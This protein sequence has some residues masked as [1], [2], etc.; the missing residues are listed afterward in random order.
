LTRGNREVTIDAMLNRDFAL[1]RLS[2]QNKMKKNFL[3]NLSASIVHL[4]KKSCGSNR[5]IFSNEKSGL[6][7]IHKMRSDLK[8]IF[9]VLKIFLFMLLVLS[10]VSSEV[11]AQDVEASEEKDVIQLAREQ[12]LA[13]EENLKE[14]IVLEN[15]IFGKRV[16]QYKFG[17]TI[18]VILVG[19]IFLFLLVK[20][21][22][23]KIR[24]IKKRHTFRKIAVYIVT[25]VITIVVFLIW[26][27][28]L[29]S[30]SIYLGVL[31]AGLALALQE[32]ILS[33]AG[34][35]L[36]VFRRPFE[37]GDRVEL[38]GVKGDIIDI[39]LFQISMLEI[40]NWVDA[41]QSTGR[42]V[43]I[44]NSLL[45]KT[46][47][48]NYSRGFEFI[49][50]EIPILVT[51][52]SDWKCGK[53]IMLKHAQ[54]FAEGLEDQVQRKIKAM[55]NRYM[56][57]YGKLTPIVYVNIKDSGVELTL[58]YLTE[59]K[60]RRASQDNLCQSILTDFEQENNIN[61][62]YPTYRIIKE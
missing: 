44:P 49:W 35:M 57:Y 53:E 9:P 29:H 2:P 19:Y 58:R 26:L 38:N 12:R 1:E 51:F 42:I 21:V 22:N 39:R 47:S 20:I 4:V 55:R 31:S 15:S 28:N 3:K 34:W 62:A 40:G 23:T 14:K 8:K 11:F 41:D 60:K 24:D 30:F 50:N 33:I 25:I 52:E 27:Q 13:I 32:V 54:K 37:V 59:S 43:H 5:I 10:C 36:I 61:F 18:F 7:K 48:F 16:I 6:N 17:R 46:Q 45:F 56:I